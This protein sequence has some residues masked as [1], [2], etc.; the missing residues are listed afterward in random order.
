MLE[1][2]LIL[3]D[4]K[5]EPLEYLQTSLHMHSHV[6]LHVVALN[7]RSIA[8]IRD[9]RPPN[10]VIIHIPDDLLGEQR[11]RLHVACHQFQIVHD[12]LSHRV[13]QLPCSLVAHPNV[14]SSPSRKDEHQ[15][16]VSEILLQGFLNN[17]NRDDQQFP[18]FRAYSFTLAACTNVIVVVHIEVED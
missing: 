6:L 14:K 17:L 15:L 3:H 10:Y 2:L 9:L 12:R 11:L 16:L 8:R 4:L 5:E 1:C 18:A 7:L 13:L